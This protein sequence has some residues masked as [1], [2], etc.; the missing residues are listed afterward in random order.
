MR[1]RDIGPREEISCAS[2][3]T[4]PDKRPARLALLVRS[5]VPSPASIPNHDLRMRSQGHQSTSEPSGIVPELEGYLSR[6]T[7]LRR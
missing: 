1:S 5:G 6:V 7:I 3:A 4:A 2:K